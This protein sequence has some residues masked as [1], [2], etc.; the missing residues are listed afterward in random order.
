MKR[1]E[2]RKV[3]RILTILPAFFLLLI[4]YFVFLAR[5]GGVG[6]TGEEME[7]TEVEIPTADTG[8]TDTDSILPIE[9]FTDIIDKNVFSSTRERPTV[10]YSPRGSSGSS[11]TVSGE[12]VLLGVVVAGNGNSIAVIRKGGKGGEENSYGAGDDIDNMVVDEILYDRVI[13]RQGEKETILE[14]KP[15]EE[16]KTKRPSKV[17]IPKKSRPR[18]SQRKVKGKGIKK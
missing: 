1:R 10:R 17:N 12:Y 5:I 11:P 4:V 18:E 13:L 7:G 16:E 8:F 3:K 2:W 6:V 9:Q 14:L 15:R